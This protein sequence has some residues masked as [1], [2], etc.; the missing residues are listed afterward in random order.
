MLRTVGRDDARRAVRSDMSAAISDP[1]LAQHHPFYADWIAG[2]SIASAQLRRRRRATTRTVLEFLARPGPRTLALHTPY[3]LR[4]GRQLPSAHP[5][6]DRPYPHSPDRRSV[7]YSGPTSSMNHSWW[8]HI[9]SPS[10]CTTSTSL[11]N[12]CPHSPTAL[13]RL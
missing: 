12:G 8:K 5:N 6:M 11:E 4:D 3:R 13:G 9:E 7:P 1:C 2:N 10:R